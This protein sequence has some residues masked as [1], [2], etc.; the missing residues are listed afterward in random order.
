MTILIPPV[1]IGVVLDL[2]TFDS[3]YINYDKNTISGMSNGQEIDIYEFVKVGITMN[4][5]MFDYKVTAS[6]MGVIIQTLP[7]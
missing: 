7:K 4:P 1:E 2:K 5:S 3:L 6:S